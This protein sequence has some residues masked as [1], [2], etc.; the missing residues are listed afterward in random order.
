M[1]K[2][3]FLI[4]SILICLTKQG[5]KPVSI[6]FFG[7]SITE[8]G[9]KDKGYITLLNE[10][11]KEKNLEQKFTLT[12][13]GIGG[14]KIYDLFFRMEK[15]VLAK[16]PDIV[17][18]WIGVNDVWH[19]SLS[20]TGTDVKKFEL[21]YSD[22]IL[23]LQKAGIKVYCCTPAGIGEKNDFSNPQDGDLNEYSKI[24][25]RITA[26][27]NAGL[28]DIRKTFLDYNMQNNKDNAYQG[29]L[30]YDGVHLNDTGNKAVA[31]LMW[32]GIIQR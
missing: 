19:K 32:D 24:I 1:V 14:N 28:I 22:I 29:I 26:A 21:M 17:V 5:E 25:R 27:A 18:I 8:L 13:S 31:Q 3:Y 12:G 16:N 9:V 7:D 6:L 15:D 11:L 30:T 10:K 4:L 20:G 23:R 2:L